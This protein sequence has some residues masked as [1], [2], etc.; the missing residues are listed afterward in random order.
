MQAAAS[1]HP[2]LY[3]QVN[4]MNP[5]P[6][7]L[8]ID[9]RISPLHQDIP[10]S[11]SNLPFLSSQQ[12]SSNI[13][14]HQQILPTNQ[15]FTPFN[16]TIHPSILQ[17]D[18]E[19]LLLALQQGQVQ[20]TQVTQQPALLHTQQIIQDRQIHQ[21]NQ[22][23]PRLRE[24][25]PMHPHMLV[26]PY[27]NMLPEQ[28]MHQ[29]HQEQQNNLLLQ[30]SIR[31]GDGQYYQANM[32]ST[33]NVSQVLGITPENHLQYIPGASIPT[34][35]HP[36]NQ[37]QFTHP[38][39]PGTQETSFTPYNNDIAQYTGANVPVT[40]TSLL[41][42]QIQIS[43]PTTPE[44]NGNTINSSEQCLSTSTRFCTPH[45]EVSGINHG[46]M[47]NTNDSLDQDTRPTISE[48]AHAPDLLKKES[49][50]KSDIPSS[51]SNDSPQTQ[52]KTPHPPKHQPN[53]RRYPVGE[54]RSVS[55]LKKSSP[56]KSDSSPPSI[57]SDSSESKRISL[58]S[59]QSSACRHLDEDKSLCAG[60]EIKNALSVFSSSLISEISNSRMRRPST[61]IFHGEDETLD[62][63]YFKESSE[64]L[65]SSTFS[66]DDTSRGQSFCDDS[67]TGLMSESRRVSLDL[68]L[69]DEFVLNNALKD[70]D[71]K[72]MAETNAG[73]HVSDESLE[74]MRTISHKPSGQR[75]M[76]A[77]KEQL[78]GRDLLSSMSLIKRASLIPTSSILAKFSSETSL[79]FFSGLQDEKDVDDLILESLN[80]SQRMSLSKKRK[81]NSSLF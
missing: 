62:D 52:R 72:I 75:I 15:Q 38:M 8:P 39:F 66:N 55:A 78:T 2:S 4:M 57:N 35:A 20:H 12:T 23:A 80:D 71:R 50:T 16:T 37:A 67:L 65:R 77:G 46:R 64:Q 51:R 13:P 79:S 21:A 58:L 32:P 28:H 53:I 24:H 70:I 41:H 30:S 27:N 3:H 14:I 68:S 1:A 26:R 22:T 19:R 54:N 81:R 17:Q 69:K 25:D 31:P 18:Q 61:I 59:N 9:H 44:T 47:P 73:R 60:S 5:S 40:N 11:V 43:H 29:S 36:N 76:S 33:P 63:I 48:C 42:D 56:T 74:T 6:S 34:V 10:S 7:T 49:P 45:Q